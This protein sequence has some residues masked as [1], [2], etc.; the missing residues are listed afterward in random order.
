MLASTVPSNTTILIPAYKPDER[1][2]SLV[3]ELRSRGLD[4]LLVDDGGGAAY[5]HIFRKAE[6]LG[7][8]VVRHAVNLGK[9]RALKTGIN[10][11]LLRP[12][13]PAVVTA[14]ADGQHTVVDILKVAD[15]MRQNPDALAL[16]ERAFT[17]KVPL[18]SRLGNGITRIIYTLITGMRCRDTQT[19]LRGLP[20]A[21]LPDMMRIP[22]E[23]YEYEMNMLLRLKELKLGLAQTPIETVYIN[24]NKGSHFNPLKD[25]LRILAVLLKFIGSSALSF[26]IDWGLYTALANAGASY[27]LAYAGARVVSA[28]FN[29]L[30]NRTIVF[31]R[32]G[33]K[34]ALRYALL[35]AVQLCIGAGLTHLLASVTPGWSF[36]VKLP[37]DI[38]LFFVNFYVQRE[39][40]FT[41]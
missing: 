28:L 21:S 17:G 4:V 39:W 25:A 8:A 29:F 32:G 14:D 33:R 35:A 11:L 20:A 26:A 34:A 15:T 37:V 13:P 1:L 16:G 6:S 9:G 38:L 12:K 7:A 31:Q 36:W 18:K 24:D 23:R 40:I 30:L 19:G 22:G 27:G 2:V 3:N 10:A 5:S 41:G